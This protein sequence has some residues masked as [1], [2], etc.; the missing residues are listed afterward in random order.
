MSE[1]TAEIMQD[2]IMVNESISQEIDHQKALDEEV[3]GN[4]KTILPRN[5]EKRWRLYGDRGKLPSTVHGDKKAIEKASRFSPVYVPC[6]Y[7]V[8][9]NQS[10]GWEPE[11]ARRCNHRFPKGIKGKSLSVEAMLHCEEKHMDWCI[12][13]S[14][15]FTER[16]RVDKKGNLRPSSNT[17]VRTPR[18]LED[19]EDDPGMTNR[20]KAIARRRREKAMENRETVEHQQG[21]TEATDDFYADVEKNKKNN[22]GKEK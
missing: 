2:E 5:M 16:L 15:G 3:M 18:W 19:I 20:D 11:N 6:P 10:G 14:G 4:L 9:K 1:E 13:T 22:K 17:N 7:P 21:M 12:E 8:K